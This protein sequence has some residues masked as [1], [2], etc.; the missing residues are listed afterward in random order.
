MI[1]FG[2]SE[3]TVKRL[4]EEYPVGCRVELIHMEDPYNRKLTPGCRGTVRS[5]DD[6]GTIHVDWDCGSR[7][8]VAYGEDSCRKVVD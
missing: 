2:I 6:I 1:M 7:L 8:G 5:V 4:K 3:A